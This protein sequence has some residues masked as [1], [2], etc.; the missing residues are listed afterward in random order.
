MTKRKV[1]LLAL[2][3]MLLGLWQVLAARAGS[4]DR[5]TGMRT[6]SGMIALMSGIGIGI[7]GL[8]LKDRQ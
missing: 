3:I 4:P 8:G 1:I 6:A 7:Y 2:A 5:T